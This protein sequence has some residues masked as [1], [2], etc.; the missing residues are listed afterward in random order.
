MPEQKSRV[1]KVEV[2]T[3]PARIN[4]DRETSYVASTKSL[5]DKEKIEVIWTVPTTEAAFHERYQTTTFK[6]IAESAV[7]LFSHTPNYG[8]LRNDFSG[9]YENFQDQCQSMADDFTVESV[10]KPGKT[11][12]IFRKASE[13]DLLTKKVQSGEMSPKQLSEY[14]KKLATST[15]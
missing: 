14:F 8:A 11:K 13:F 15:E 1:V 10:R 6:D 7:K 2:A 12:A 9:S 4:Y 5:A 3:H